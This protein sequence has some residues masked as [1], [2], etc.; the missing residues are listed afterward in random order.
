MACARR[1]CRDERMYCKR[2]VSVFLMLRPVRGENTISARSS[3]PVE[4]VIR[5]ESRACTK[6]TGRKP[7]LKSCT[8]VLTFRASG[9]SSRSYCKKSSA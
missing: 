9:A 2:T 6:H 4:P 3:Y 8:D 7:D 1:L 5:Y